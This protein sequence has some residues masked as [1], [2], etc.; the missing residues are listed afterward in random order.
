MGYAWPRTS[1]FVPYCLLWSVREMISPRK[2]RSSIFVVRF[3]HSSLLCIVYAR[4]DGWSAAA[5]T[6]HLTARL[7]GID[8]AAELILHF[9]PEPENG[10]TKTAGHDD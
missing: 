2:R 8:A 7:Q 4:S 1:A 6:L 3:N 9:E 10:Q 5:A